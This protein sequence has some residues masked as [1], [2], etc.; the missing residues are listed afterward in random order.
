MTNPRRR[1]NPITSEHGQTMA[2]YSLLIVLIALALFGG[3]PPI[4]SALIGFF[5]SFASGL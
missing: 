4:T 2:E 3:L 1:I 5:S